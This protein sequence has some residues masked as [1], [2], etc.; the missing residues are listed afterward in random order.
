[1]ENDSL[2]EDSY[3]SDIRPLK[4]QKRNVIESDSE[5]DFDE[6]NENITPSCREDMYQVSFQLT[7]H[8]CILK[9]I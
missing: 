2:S 7:M 9:F 1:M 8:E 6:C 5:S 3:E 4:W